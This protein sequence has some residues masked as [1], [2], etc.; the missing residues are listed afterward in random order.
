MLRVLTGLLLLAFI[1]PSAS[2]K[3]EMMTYEGMEGIYFAVRSGPYWASPESWA[4]RPYTNVEFVRYPA[5]IV[6]QDL[7]IKV[8]ITGPLKDYDRE[9]VVEINP[10]STTAVENVHYLPFPRTSIVPA[11]SLFG[12][13][14]ITVKRTA[15]MLDK[16]IKLGLRLVRN[17]NFDL[18]FPDWKA[19]PDVGQTNLGTDTAFDAT[20]HTININ[21]LMVQPEVWRGSVVAATNK[22]TGLW[23]AFTRKKLELMCE[24]L[25]ISYVDFGSDETMSLVLSSVIAGELSRYLVDKFNAGTPVL[26][27][28]GRLMWAGTVPW[29]SFIGVPYQ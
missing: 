27:D 7:R 9:F 2:C 22:E 15:E 3:K 17:K 18:A 12:Y 25:D 10:D 21:D 19:L 14:P 23:G 13:I 8:M 24:L 4:Y 16:N 5:D 26:E 11:D 20:L 28:D 29:E 6:E 1:L